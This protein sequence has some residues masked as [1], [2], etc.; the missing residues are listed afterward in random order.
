MACWSTFIQQ[1]C[2]FHNFLFISCQIPPIQKENK[3]LCS[4]VDILLKL[5]EQSR[6]VQ[7][8]FQIEYATF[9]YSCHYQWV[10]TIQC[11]SMLSITTKNSYRIRI[12]SR[13]LVC[14]CDKNKP[15]FFVFCYFKRRP[16]LKT[17]SDKDIWAHGPRLYWYHAS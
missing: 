17:N 10:T 13:L 6:S 4:H 12:Y 15:S 8:V 3:R 14:L 2:I 7:H 9:R 1:I 5:Q 16:K 11:N